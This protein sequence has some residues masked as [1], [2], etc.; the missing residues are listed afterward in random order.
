M[1]DR[2][3]VAVWPDPG[4][5]GALRQ[6]VDVALPAHPDV[7]WQPEQRWHITLAFL[8]DV[9]P[10][11]TA[12]RIEDLAH[13]GLPPAGA[14][15]LNGAGTFGPILWVGV[16]HGAWLADLAALLQRRLHVADRRFRAHVTVGRT[17][18]PDAVRLAR[19]AAASLAG[20]RGPPWTP[21]GL[22]LVSSVNGPKPAYRVLRTWPLAGG[23]GGRLDQPTPAA[24]R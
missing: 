10:D 5:R 24:P 18:G 7:R 17:R 21:H 2:L 11:R 23:Q 16:E 4:A 22:T 15:R 19:T 9:E 3:F 1:T 6:A 8:G 12:A 13:R 20:H 14:I